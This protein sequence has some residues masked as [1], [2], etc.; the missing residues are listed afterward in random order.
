MALK[1]FDLQCEAGHVFEGW[2]GSDDSYESQKDAGQLACPV[3]NSTSIQKKLAAPRINRS[4]TEA[5]Q[6]SSAAADGLEG[7]AIRQF[8]AKLFDKMREV[9][10]NSENVG[11]RFAEEVRRIHDGDAKERAIRGTATP[12]ERDQ[13][14]EDGIDVQ[15]I[16]DFLDDD[17]MQ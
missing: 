1:V 5:S 11:P 15:L 13:L 7:E 3:C 12:E 16:P 14:Q 6:P 4:S 8:Q 17:R 10:R 9:I 2:F